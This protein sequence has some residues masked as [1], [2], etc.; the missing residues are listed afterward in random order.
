MC[1]DR[2]HA[3]QHEVHRS[4]LRDGHT[5]PFLAHRDKRL[6]AL[7]ELS[8]H[9]HGAPRGR[10]LVRLHVH[11]RPYLANVLDGVIHGLELSKNRK[12]HCRKARG[13][14]AS[15]GAVHENV[16]PKSL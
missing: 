12:E 1:R 10:Y 4:R 16:A 9:L 5:P 11:L 8:V 2:A 13:A 14:A 7:H 6:P 3:V 15:V